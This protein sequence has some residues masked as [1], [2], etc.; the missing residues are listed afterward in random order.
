MCIYSLF[1]VF[2]MDKFE[3]DSC[4]KWIEENNF[5]TIALQLPDE[6][7]DKVQDLID[8]LTSSISSRD[9]ELFLVGDGCSPCCNDLLNAQYC[10]AQGLIHFG[11]SC[12]SSSSDNNQQTISIL[13][14]FYQQPLPYVFQKYLNVKGNA[15][16]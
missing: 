13:Y 11:H 6:D 4:I 1:D 10:Q 15:L 8:I 9:I 2:Q 16:C 7:L 12:L 14:V 5:N 3:I